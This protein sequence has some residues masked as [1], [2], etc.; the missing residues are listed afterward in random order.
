MNESNQLKSVGLKITMPRLRILQVLMQSDAHHL[1][2]ED[3]YRTLNDLN[4]NVSLATVYRVLTQF[5]TTGLVQRHNFEG[6]YAVYEL[7]TGNHHDHLV[8]TNCGR[9]EEFLDE[10]IES[11]QHSIAAKAQ[12]KMTS[13]ALNIYGICSDC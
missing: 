8:C 4:E 6:G 10:V 9:V 13:H 2:A 5:E 1:S 11:R 3:V 12:F 7:R